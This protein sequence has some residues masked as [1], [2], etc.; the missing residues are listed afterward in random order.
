MTARS[1]S[2]YQ[3]PEG[4]RQNNAIEVVHTMSTDRFKENDSAHFV[5]FSQMTKCS[6]R[7]SSRMT[8]ACWW[9]P[10][11]SS[12]AAGREQKAAELIGS[13]KLQQKKL[14]EHCHHG[15]HLILAIRTLFR[16]KPSG[17]ILKP[18]EMEA[19]HFPVRRNHTWVGWR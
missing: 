10:S 12:R 2:R 1:A 14:V 13:M 4:W 17:T 3:Q 16:K 15:D 18:E 9:R 5:N 8:C 6:R 11:H 19:F 7:R